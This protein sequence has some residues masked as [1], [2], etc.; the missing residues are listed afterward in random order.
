MPTAEKSI[1]D[2]LVALLTDELADLKVDSRAVTVVRELPQERLG[3]G[4][5]PLVVV[6]RPQMQT[7]EAWDYGRRRKVFAV[8]VLCVDAVEVSVVGQ[9]T[10][11]ELLDQLRDNVIAQIRSDRWAGLASLWV[12][13]SFVGYDLADEPEPVGNN[14]LSL[15]LR[16]SIPVIVPV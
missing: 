2:G 16:L 11:R 6:T 5:L 9:R 8:D 7:D 4:S 12:F 1:Q 10:S 15:M 3:Q 14:L 13:E